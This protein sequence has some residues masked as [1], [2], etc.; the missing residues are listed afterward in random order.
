M[1]VKTETKIFLILC[2][3]K[4]EFIFYCKTSCVASYQLRFWK[5]GGDFK[6]TPQ[7]GYIQ[8]HRNHD[9]TTPRHPG[10]FPDQTGSYTFTLS[11]PGRE[12]WRFKKEK[13]VWKTSVGL[14]PWQS[15]R[16]KASFYPEDKNSTDH[17]AGSFPG[18]PTPQKIQKQQTVLNK[19][20]LLINSS[21]FQLHLLPSPIDLD[22]PI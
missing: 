9:S 20:T 19:A 4:T 3:L 10:Y 11:F 12:S 18:C 14:V 13:Q 17:G 7:P 6:H 1:I 5:E 15:E 21:G 2:C 16:S 22:H 8:K